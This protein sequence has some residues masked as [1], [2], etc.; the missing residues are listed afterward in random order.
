MC[1]LVLRLMLRLMLW[2]NVI[3]GSEV[4][5]LRVVFVSGLE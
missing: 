3:L 2:C 1:S 5:F 4:D